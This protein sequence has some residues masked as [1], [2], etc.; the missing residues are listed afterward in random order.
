MRKSSGGGWS[1]VYI[2]AERLVRSG[3]RAGGAVRLGRKDPAS[4]VLRLEA[5]KSQRM[6]NLSRSRTRVCCAVLTHLRYFVS[7]TYKLGR[8]YKKLYKATS[9]SRAESQSR[10]RHKSLKTL[11]A[12]QD[13]HK[14]RKTAQIARSVAALRT[15]TMLGADQSPSLSCLGTRNLLILY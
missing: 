15:T 12:E 1:D 3:D 6:I 14:H 4:I 9:T 13:Q 10:N 11:T 2:P 7:L 8:T 5:D